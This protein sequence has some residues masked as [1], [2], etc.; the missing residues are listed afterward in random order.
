MSKE[1][2]LKLF[3]LL[4]AWL[5]IVIVP[6]LSLAQQCL[7]LAE[8]VYIWRL[9]RLNK[10]R[11]KEPRIHV[12]SRNVLIYCPNIGGHRPIYAAKFID[13]YLMRGFDV[14]FVYCGLITSGKNRVY[15]KIESSFLNVFKDNERFHDVCVLGKITKDTDEL[16]FVVDLQ[17]KCIAFLT[18]FIDGDAMTNTFYRQVRHGAPRL[19]G[20]NHAV[21]ILLD[22]PYRDMRLNCLWKEPD[23]REQVMPL[24]FHRCRFKYL[25]LLDGALVSDENLF[26]QLKPT[27]HLK[28]GDVIHFEAPPDEDTRRK[29]F[30]KKVMKDY[31]E[32]LAN[33]AGKDIILHFGENE[34]R[35]GF[36]FLLRLVAEDPDLVLVRAGRTKPSW[37][38]SWDSI[39]MK[40]QLMIEGRLFEVDM[41]IDSQEFIAK[42]FSSIKYFLF[43]YKNHFRTSILMTMVLSYGKPV[44]VPSLGL[45]KTRVERNKVGRVYQHK[46]Y[47][48]FRE[49]FT[50]LR[51]EHETYHENI[52]KYHDNEFSD[53]AWAR[54]VDEF[55]L[56][57]IKFDAPNQ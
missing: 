38:I 48:S 14:Y 39:L 27:K 50:N 17:K 32:F 55:T 9:K 51:D 2:L 23:K 26:S 40:E 52:K 1:N 4:K 20:R 53:E 7:P 54:R 16:S 36:D 34:L 33:N 22:F 5:G 13:H 44:M 18:I 57:D 43:A 25:D 11:F 28:L 30:F 49:E 19:I 24:I 46:N 29:L 56:K 41:F 31:D 42:L 12:D 15:S 35:K 6:L 10:K 47:A 8:K 21:F 3:K 45:M 37:K